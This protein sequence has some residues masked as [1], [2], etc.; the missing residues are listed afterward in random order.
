M[1]CN[2]VSYFDVC[3]LACR[4]SPVFVRPVTASKSASLLSLNSSDSD[5]KVIKYTSPLQ[6]IIDSFISPSSSNKSNKKQS[7]EL[8]SDVVKFAKDNNLGPVC[9]FPESTTSNGRGILRYQK[10]FDDKLNKVLAGQPSSKVHIIG[11]KYNYQ[12]FS[13]AFHIWFNSMDFYQHLMESMF[14]IHNDMVVRIVDGVSAKAE[15][16]VDAT[17]AKWSPL[18]SRQTLANL[19]GPSLELNYER[20]QEF[21]DYY[22]K[23]TYLNKTK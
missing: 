8:L 11:F 17:A 21:L 4:L 6:F 2:H 20:K 13:P 12:H 16:E 23:N 5:V 19:V 14:Q 10:V 7:G 22:H 15:E 1:I 18:V 9:V 3:Y